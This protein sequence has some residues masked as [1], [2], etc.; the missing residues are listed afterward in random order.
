MLKIDVGEFSVVQTRCSVLKKAPFGKEEI[1]F[2]QGFLKEM[3]LQWG[4]KELDQQWQTDKQKRLD[5]R[6][7]KDLVIYKM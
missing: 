4:E 6:F 7:S 3:L 2:M 5:L 1:V